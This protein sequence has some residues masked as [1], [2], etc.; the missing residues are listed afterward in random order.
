MRKLTAALVIISVVAIS[1]GGYG[2]FLLLSDKSQDTGEVAQIIADHTA[3]V[4]YSRIPDQ[5]ISAV[6]KMWVNIPGESHAYA[7]RDGLEFLA[8]AEPKFAV[9]AIDSGSPE[10]YTDQH[11]RSCGSVRNEW[12]NWDDGISEAGFWTTAEGVTRVKN[13]INYS[14]THD[15]HITALGF[16]WCW[17]MV[18]GNDESPDIDPVN[19]CHWY[20][21]TDGSSGG[22]WGLDAGDSTISCLTYCQQVDDYNVYCQ[23]KGFTTKVLFTTGTVD[24]YTDE[25]GYQGYLKNEYIRTYVK[26]NRTRVLF[27]Y[28]DI[29]CYNDA[30]ERA[31]TTWN[32]QEYPI[33]HPDNDYNS[34]YSNN[35]GHIGAA[36]ALRLAKAQWWLLA[37]LAGWDGK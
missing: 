20:G 33:I 5:Y 6:K 19:G 3:V 27:D 11:L 24:S 35:T 26:S 12:D 18:W 36:G 9:S 32:G 29:L 31:T 28:G 37:R 8:L 7:Y 34:E 13:H 16:G 10:A 22:W 2:I 15:L 25:R 30:G 17:D 21:T 1:A 14:E 4:N 23:S